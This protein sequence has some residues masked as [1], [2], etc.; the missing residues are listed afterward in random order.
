MLVEQTPL[1]AS[2]SA[3][4]AKEASRQHPL[5]PLSSTEIR[6]TGELIKGIYLQGTGL[7]Y[8]QITLREPDKAYLAPWL[9]AKFDGKPV[10]PLD[11]KADVSYYIRN[12]VCDY[13]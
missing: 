13:V 3:R 7:L 11:R 1:G 6:A 10:Q 2:W 9:D 12:T 4:A 5:S 8:K